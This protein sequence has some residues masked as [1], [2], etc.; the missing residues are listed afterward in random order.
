[1]NTRLALTAT[2][3]ASLTQ[4][5]HAGVLVITNPGFESPATATVSSNIPD[6]WT[7][8]GATGGYWNINAFPAGFWN[9][10]APEGNQVGYVVSSGESGP[11]SLAQ[12]LSDSLQANTRYTLSGMVGH[13]VGYGATRD[14]D[15]VFG[16]DLR[17]GGNILASTSGIAPE[18]SFQPFELVFDSAGSPFIGQPLE[19]RLFSS[20]PQTAYDAIQLI[21][22]PEPEHYVAMC[23]A[24]LGAFGL[25]LRTRRQAGVSS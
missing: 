7:A 12:T 13:P 4:L 5:A 24:A 9:V 14:P 18:G 19:I 10:P 6:G 25:L 1:M 20:Q 22:V 17:A 16:I 15:T 8:N 11:G 21:A 3:T 23:G 2:L